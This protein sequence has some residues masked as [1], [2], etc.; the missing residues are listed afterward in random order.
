MRR[1]GPTHPPTLQA[2]PPLRQLLPLLLISTLAL[3]QPTTAARAQHEK[4]L[5]SRV[6]TLTVRAERPTTHRRVPAV[7]Q[8]AC[9]GGAARGLFALDALQCRNQGSDYG[10]ESVQWACAASLPPEFRL[11]ATEVVCEGWAHSADRWV[12]SGSCAVRYSLHLTEEG[13][14]RYGGGG[15]KGEGSWLG[16]EDGEDGD[17]YREWRG[18]RGRNTV[19]GVLF[20]ALFVGVLGWMVYAAFFRGRGR[21]GRAG[22]LGGAGG[23]GWG[24]W[25][26]GGGGGGNPFN[27][28]SSDPP[29][30][31]SRS[32]KGAGTTAAPRSSN[33]GWGARQR[34]AGSS[35]IPGFL[36]GAAGGA[37][38][39]FAAGRFASRGQRPESSR[40]AAQRP[41]PGAG[42]RPSSSSAP[43]P[44][45]S[46]ARYESTG[47][48]GTSRR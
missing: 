25:G 12:L 26:P 33:A 40:Q 7:P 44:G 41:E 21:E 16:G 46:S 32:A 28:E 18:E 3:I 15:R 47:F 22:R 43:G 45:Y 39:G 1:P 10:A 8:L 13:E 4:I 42:S 36:G 29:P 34:G 48:G 6:Q 2:P 14:R 31:Y 27:D 5:L 24:G 35:W 11:G 19:A 37:A 30:P 38:A 23:G 20:W 17:G 9:T